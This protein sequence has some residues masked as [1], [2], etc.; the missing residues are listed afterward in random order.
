MNTY[1]EDS[2]R[3]NDVGIKRNDNISGTEL[4]KKLQDVTM[5]E[6]I[7]DIVQDDHHDD[8]DYASIRP[9]SKTIHDSNATN[10]ITTMTTTTN[11]H[12]ETND[13]ITILQNHTNAFAI[14]YYRSRRK[15]INH[16]NSVSVCIEHDIYLYIRDKSDSFSVAITFFAPNLTLVYKELVY[17]ARA[18]NLNICVENQNACQKDGRNHT[19][20]LAQGHPFRHEHWQAVHGAWL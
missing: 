4:N 14:P 16:V 9:T 3:G 20:A 2:N 15:N 7:Y 1:S 11:N 12:D 5:Q 19:S 18:Y 13:T 6:K 10:D 8:N 17:S